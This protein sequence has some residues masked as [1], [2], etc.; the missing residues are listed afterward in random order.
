[1]FPSTLRLASR[2]LLSAAISWSLIPI[3]AAD[4]PGTPSGEPTKRLFTVPEDGMGDSE[5]LSGAT[6]LVREILMKRPNEDLV[7]CVAGCVADD[8]VVYAQPAEEIASKKPETA[9]TNAPSA[10]VASAEIPIK[11]DTPVAETKG[12]AALKPTF[13]PTSSESKSDAFHGDGDTDAKP[14]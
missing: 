3:A 5:W 12:T 6:R 13:V 9:E 2:V 1:M 8:R 4:A 10:P 7:I 14:N 11:K